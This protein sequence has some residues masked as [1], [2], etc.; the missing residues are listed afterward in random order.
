MLGESKILSSQLFRLFSKIR[1]LGIFTLGVRKRRDYIAP[2][3]GHSAQFFSSWLLLIPSQVFPAAPVIVT[4]EESSEH[5]HGLEM[6]GSPCI[7]LRV[8]SLPLLKAL[9][10]RAMLNPREQSP[11]ESFAVQRCFVL[12]T[13]ST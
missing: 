7:T 2:G 5:A 12:G 4:T 9:S 3:T 1:K 6:L 13:Y 11:T 10:I 8:S